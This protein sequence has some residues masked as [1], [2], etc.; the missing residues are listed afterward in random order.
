MGFL[1]WL[2]GRSQADKVTPT[3]LT[4]ENFRAELGASDLPALIDVWSPTCA[5]CAK[6]APVMVKLANRYRDRVRVFHVNAADSPRLMRQLGVSG[7]PTVIVM[8]RGAEMGRVVGYRPQSW[9][10]QM[11]DAEFPAPPA[12]TGAA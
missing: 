3:E 4:D 5:P 9:F 7:T 12:G 10:E 8:R 1:S 6:L 2:T 11:I